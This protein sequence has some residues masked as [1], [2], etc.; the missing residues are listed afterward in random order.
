[1]TSTSRVRLAVAVLA[2]LVAG[3]AAVTT[4]GSSA[5]ASPSVTVDTVAA[6]PATTSL[7]FKTDNCEGCTVQLVQAVSGSQDVW[8]SRAKK[9][10]GGLV[11][12]SF[13]TSHTHG[14]SASVRPTWEGQD[15]GSTG[16][17]TMV[18][19]RYQKEAPGDPVSFREARSKH[20]GSA[21]WAGTDESRVVLPLK[22]RRVTVQGNTGPT[23]GSI[24][25]TRTTQEWWRPML[26]AWKGVLGAQDAVFCDQP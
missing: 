5:Q 16:Y 14:L 2:T 19:F 21:C 20:R 6:K 11:T 8:Q 7:T 10:R 25:W 12:F 22:I 4:G 24:A 17:V 1:M 15:G 26:P 3:T 18:A 23:A 9:V 13:R